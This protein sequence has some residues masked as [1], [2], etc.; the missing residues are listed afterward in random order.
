M[1]SPFSSAPVRTYGMHERADHLDFDIRFQ[2]ARNE[3]TL[4]HRHAYFQIQ[5]GLDGSTQQA[6]G[7]AVRPFGP[8]T[9]S[10]VLPYRI[11][12]IPHPPGSRYCIVNFDQRFL[13]PSLEVDALDLEDV[14][15]SRHPEL[16]PFLFQEYADFAFDEA[17]FARIRGWLEELQ[18]HNGARSFGA[19]TTIR[20]IVQQII[21][22]ACLRQDATL[23]R[24]SQQ[25]NGKTS[26][27]DALQRV[28]RYVRENLDKDLSLT[29]AAA[30]A[31]LSPN[32]LAHL[33]KKETDRTFTD[34]VTERRLERAKE[35]LVSS[36]LLVREVAHQCGFSDEAYFNRRFRQWVGCT[37]RQFRDEHVARIRA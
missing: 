11:H 27:R 2:G 36:A 21:G 12:V 5:I 20:G 1:S 24:L 4:P 22:L 37:P 7:G 17:D 6:I 9:L 15:L 16:A 14:P 32:Y 30:A 33:L 18:L 28:V 34:M 10:F 35:L 19:M 8:G 25:H 26:Q 29:D 31:F 13:W 23:L 3:L